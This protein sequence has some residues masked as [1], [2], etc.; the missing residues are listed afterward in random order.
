MFWEIQV[1]NKDR[2]FYFPREAQECTFFYG[3]S[4]QADYRM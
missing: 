3:F 4:L 2:R 1:T